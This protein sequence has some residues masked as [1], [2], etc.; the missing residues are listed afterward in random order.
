MSETQGLLGR[1]SARIA[2]GVV[3]GLAAVE[4]VTSAFV[5]RPSIDADD[6]QAASA[7]LAVLP[8][9]E[10]VWL[11]TPWLGPRARLHLPR[12]AG[13]DSVAPA[14]LRGAPRFHVLGRSGDAWAPTL[15]ADLEDLPAPTLVETRSLGGLSLS[16][17]EQAQAGLVLA[18]FV[19]EA[20][21]LVVE[22]DGG[23]CRG[24]GRRTCD[25]GRVGP[26]TAEVDYRPRRCLKVELSDGATVRLRYP[27]MA[28]GDVLRGHV[29][30]HDFN[31]R[32]RSD[33]PLRL[34]VSID[35]E[36]VGQWLVSDEQSWWPFAIASTPGEHDVQLE[37]TP[38][39]RGTWQ[40]SGYEPGRAHAPCVELRSL[41]E[42]TS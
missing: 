30:F 18:D 6:W 9:E 12:V 22:T 8:A 41:Q 13:W 5:Y 19:A 15:Q 26:A 36:R 33:A 11:G 1:R 23:R 25:E 37:L 20:S 3:L 27:E 28:T 14:D 38:A 10:P 16:T 32:L 24:K 40:R 31:A 39:V 7:A 29:A 34:R 4:L 42:G 35:G 17:Y 21:N 2:L